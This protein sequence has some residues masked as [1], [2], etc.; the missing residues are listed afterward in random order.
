MKTFIQHLVCES[1]SHFFDYISPWTYVEK[2][3]AKLFPDLEARSSF[4]PQV[5]FAAAFPLAPCIGA[6]LILVEMRVDTSADSG[7]VED[8]DSAREDITKNTHTRE[9]IAKMLIGTD[10]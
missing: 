10:S 1:T 8:L 4:P 3:I 2:L 7:G 9:Y 5:L 6:F